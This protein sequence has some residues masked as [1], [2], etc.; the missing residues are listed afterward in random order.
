MNNNTHIF[1]D[2]SGD[3]NIGQDILEWKIEGLKV[4]IISIGEYET[5]GT[6]KLYSNF[7][8][9]NYSVCQLF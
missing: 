2:E 7:S 5:S 8:M 1:F 3:P 4:N 6:I 9:D